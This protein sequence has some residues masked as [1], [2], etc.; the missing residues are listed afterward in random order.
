[1]YLTST[2]AGDR[3]LKNASCNLQVGIFAAVA[4]GADSGDDAGGKLLRAQ[5]ERGPAAGE[6]MI[7]AGRRRVHFVTAARQRPWPAIV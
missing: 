7:Q 6:P 4:T 2:L 1:M 3:R 5:A